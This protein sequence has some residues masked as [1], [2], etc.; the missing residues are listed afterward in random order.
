MTQETTI[1]VPLDWLARA[2]NLLNEMAGEGI[3]M[4][5]C[6]EPSDLMCEIA[7]HLGHGD[8]DDLWS[9]VTVA[10]NS[11]QHLRERRAKALD[12]LMRQDGE[13]L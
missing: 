9:A 6:A 2:V 3:S 5:D 4:E 7:Q 10:L 12:D 8:A 13:L 1:A 11:E